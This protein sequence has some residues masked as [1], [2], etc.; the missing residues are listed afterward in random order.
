MEKTLKLGENTYK[1]RPMTLGTRR[2]YHNSIKKDMMA[3]DKEALYVKLHLMEKNGKPVTNDD[4]NNLLNN[5]VNCIIHAINGLESE[6]IE[7]VFKTEVLINKRAFEDVERQ[8]NGYTFEEALDR[9][10][11]GIKIP[12]SE[13]DGYVV[14]A[15]LRRYYNM[16]SR[17]IENLEEREKLAYIKLMRKKW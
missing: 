5:E 4:V 10:I 2:K 14:N 7:K 13:I 3:G 12:N 6:V 16:S 15:S 1:V 8:I 11:E 9:K 17:D